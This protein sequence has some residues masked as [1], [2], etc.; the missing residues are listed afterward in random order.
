MTERLFG[1]F[2]HKMIGYPK[3]FDDLL[4][5]DHHI[6]SSSLHRATDFAFYKLIFIGRDTISIL[7]LRSSN[8]RNLLN[9]NPS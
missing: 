1:E 4:D 7:L 8:M 9:I 6:Q 3:N 5:H 2:G